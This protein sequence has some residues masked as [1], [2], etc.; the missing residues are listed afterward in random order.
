M[1]VEVFSSIGIFVSISICLIS[2][3][4]VADRGEVDT[5]LVGTTGLDSTLEEGMLIL[6]LGFQGRIVGH[7]SL[8]SW[9]NTH[10]SLVLCIFD[11]EKSGT[12]GIS[13][14]R[15][16]ANNDGM[17]DLFDP[18]SLEFREEE[19]EGRLIFDDDYHSTG[20]SIDT[21]KE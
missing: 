7:G 11:S 17:V 6:D 1:D 2:E 19:L 21:M 3:D 14:L 18:T 12:D 13:R 8:T 9:I 10:L 5:N 16:S 4:R 20:F 15:G